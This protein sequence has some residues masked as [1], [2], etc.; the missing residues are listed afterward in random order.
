MASGIG[1][2]HANSLLNADFEN[3]SYTG[4]ATIYCALF[5]AAPSDTGVGTEA[6]YGSYARQAV[7]C[8]TTTF[9]A[10]SGGA[11]TGSNA[12]ITFPTS[13][14]TSNTITDVAWMAASSGGSQPLY[15]GDLS[16]S[17]SIATG[18]TPQFN[19]NAITISAV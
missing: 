6:T 17:Q 3:S 14:G 8:S 1:Q 11:I 10:A 7:T 15:W 16:A 13:T 12:A 2:T 19:A 4:P 9:P 5:T 18:N